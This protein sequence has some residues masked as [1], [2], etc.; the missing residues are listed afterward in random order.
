MIDAVER[1]YSD[2]VQAFGATPCGV[3][4]NGER[5]QRLR[6]AHLLDALPDA[7]EELA[8]LDYGCGYGALLDSLA[9]RRERFRY[10]G[11]DISRAM[12]DEAR[13]RYAGEPRATFTSAAGELVPAAVTLASG[14]FNVKLEAA[15]DAWRR[16]VYDTIDRMASLTTRRLAFNALTAHADYDRTRPHLFYMDPAETLDHCLR[17]LSRDVRLRH[18]YELYEFT[19]VVALDGR[20]PARRPEPEPAP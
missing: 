3:D 11:Y 14:I 13:R 9:A 15:D 1:Y 6:F 12:V 7:D 5:G 10:Q 20:P 8:I 16:H 2:R 19:I 4:W 18:D 17:T